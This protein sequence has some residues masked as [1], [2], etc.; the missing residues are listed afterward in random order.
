MAI[1]VPALVDG[2]KTTVPAARLRGAVQYREGITGDYLSAAGYNRAMQLASLAVHRHAYFDRTNGEQMTWHYDEA[3]GVWLPEHDGWASPE[4]RKSVQKSRGSGEWTSTFLNDG[5]EALNITDKTVFR[6]INAWLEQNY[7]TGE[8]RRELED[9]GA[10]YDDFI[11]VNPKR[12]PLLLVRLRPDIVGYEIKDFSHF[13][14]GLPG[15]GW[16]VAYD[17]ETGF[18]SMTSPD[19]SVAEQVFGNDASHF[20]AERSGLRAVFRGFD[21]KG[22]GP[23]GINANCEPSGMFPYIGGRPCV[24]S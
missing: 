6:T 23:F 21:I 13:S 8:V 1:Q 2:K 5:R 3:R 20:L 9:L 16:A 11:L 10:V 14:C 15:D 7:G 4:Y 22:N 18:P 12:V 24:K 19:R 17:A